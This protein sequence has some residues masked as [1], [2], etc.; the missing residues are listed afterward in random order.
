MV[1]FIDVDCSVR[2]VIPIDII[3]DVG[4]IPILILV[5]AYALAAL[6]MKFV[7]VAQIYRH[8]HRLRGLVLAYRKFFL[9]AYCI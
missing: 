7:R 2:N 8:V 1:G 5:A 3:V 4:L 6:D 9:L